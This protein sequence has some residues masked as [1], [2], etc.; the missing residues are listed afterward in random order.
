MLCI[1]QNFGES[2]TSIAGGYVSSADHEEVVVATY[3]G[4]IMGLTTQTSARHST[5]AA[6]Q[7]SQSKITALK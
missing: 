7:E 3:N 6:S 4:R 2:I 1:L 5:P